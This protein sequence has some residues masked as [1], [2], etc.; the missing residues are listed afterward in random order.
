M[1]GSAGVEVSVT[2][3]EFVESG[4]EGRTGV[5][6]CMFKVGGGDTTLSFEMSLTVS[7]DNGGGDVVNVGEIILGAGCNG[8]G[9]RNRGGGEKTR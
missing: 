1:A 6:G 2:G 3:A 5:D 8:G 9:D 4:D 7:L